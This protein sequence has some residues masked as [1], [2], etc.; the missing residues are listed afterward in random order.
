MKIYCCSCKKYTTHDLLR[1]YEAYVI[2]NGNTGKVM[3]KDL[4]NVYMESE[5]FS[6]RKKCRVCGWIN[7]EDFD[8]ANQID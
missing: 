7:Y 3:K 5:Y 1:S 6:E 4:P 8:M 2:V